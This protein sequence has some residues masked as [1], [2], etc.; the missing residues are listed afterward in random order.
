M[1]VTMHD[2]LAVPLLE[3]GLDF[4][5]LPHEYNYPETSI[6]RKDRPLH[7]IEVIYLSDYLTGP[8]VILIQESG[9]SPGLGRT[10]FAWSDEDWIGLV[11]K[12]ISG[13]LMEPAPAG[14]YVKKL[15]Q[16]V[17]ARPKHSTYR[18]GLLLAIE[19]LEGRA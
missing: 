2:S 16:A 5:W 9:D 14:A 18:D 1:S 15:E 13:W 12:C 7:T 17:A 3:S 8:G 19:I 6:C 11:K 10:A 4:E